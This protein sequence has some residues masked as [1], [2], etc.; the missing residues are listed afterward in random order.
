[1]SSHPLQTHPLI[2]SLRSSSR[3]LVRE[4]GFMSSNLAGTSYSASAVH[5][6]IEIGLHEQETATSPSPTPS[7]SSASKVNGKAT[8]TGGITAA[9]LCTEL[10]LEKS[11]VSRLLKKLVE[12]GEVKE[13][14]GEDA[15]EKVLR[16]TEKGRGTLAGIDAFGESQILAAFKQLPTTATP[17]DI[18]KGIS[19][20]ATALRYSRLNIPPSTST[21]S[22]PSSSPSL[23]H[24]TAPQPPTPAI[25]ITT[26]YR[27]G[28]LARCLTMH[29]TTY[30]PF[31]F[32]VAFESMLSTGLGELLSRLDGLNS[33]AFTALDSSTH[34]ILGTVFMDGVDL[35]RKTNTN[36]NTNTEAGN[37]YL[38]PLPT[39]G[40]TVK[41]VHLRG[42]VVD[43]SIRGAGVG[44]RMLDAALK[45][46]E[47]RAFEEVHLWTFKGLDAARRL[48]EGRGFVLRDQEARKMWEGKELLVQHFVRGG[49][50]LV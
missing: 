34:E 40:N 8:N 41:K 17:D 36:T 13:G 23:I 32:G 33:E 6:I 14:F 37:E 31:G 24:T 25:T 20:Y 15:R 35:S 27:L 48:Y 2:P 39:D 50:G 29:M 28:L 49:R 5:A 12:A 30:T 1:M 42:F 18:L 7:S 43:E 38:S 10:N 19:A 9:T 47:E 3:L 45:W 4:L 11:S 46:A 16:L 26:G 22:K 44:K 21:T